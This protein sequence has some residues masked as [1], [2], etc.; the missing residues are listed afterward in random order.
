MG[1]HLVRCWPGEIIHARPLP[2]S[3]P[4]R[5]RVRFEALITLGVMRDVDGRS[6][7]HNAAAHSE[8]SS[9][10]PVRRAGTL[11]AD[12]RI[13]D[14]DLSFLCMAIQVDILFHLAGAEFLR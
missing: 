5:S 6:A 7:A 2:F 8:P 1:L 3:G 13:H 9:R 10:S 4:D 12:S 14:R 11:D